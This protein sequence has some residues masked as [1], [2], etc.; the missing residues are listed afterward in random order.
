MKRN[1]LLALL[2]SLCLSSCIEVESSLSTNNSESSNLSEETSNS[3]SSSLQQS[4]NDKESTNLQQSSTPEVSVPETSTP[5]VSVP[6][7]ST[8][9][10]SVPESSIPEEST[11]DKESSTPEDSSSAENVDIDPNATKIELGG[12]GDYVTSLNNKYKGVELFEMYNGL[13]E[14]VEGSQNGIIKTKYQKGLQEFFNIDNKISIKVDI[15]QSELVKINEYHDKGNEESYRICD[16]DITLNDLIFHYE[17]VGIRLKGNTSRGHVVSG[18]K[19]NLRHYKLNFAEAF[20]DEFRSD[21]MTWTDEEA[22]AYRDD[23]TFFGLEKLDIRWNRNQEKTYIREYYAYEMYRNNGMLAPHTNPF[24]LSF[25]VDGNNQNAG[26]YLAVEPIDKDFLKR[27]LAKSYRNG[28]LYKLGWTNVG[29]TFDSV[30]SRLFGEETQIVSGDGFKTLKYPYDI[31]TNKKT[32]THADIKNFINLLNST[33]ASNFKQMLEANT[34]YDMLMKYFAISYL[35]GDPDDL[36][37]N[38]NNTYVYFIP[39]TETTNAL[40]VF[41]PT[42]HDRVLGSSGGTNPSEMKHN[43]YTDPFAKKTGY[44]ENNMPLYKKSIL[45]S[46]NT[47]IRNDYLN[48]IQGVIDSSYMSIDTFKTYYNKAKA[49]YGNSTTLGNKFNDSDVGFSLNENNDPNNNSNLSIEKYLTEKVNTASK[50]IANNNG[51]NTPS[52]NPN[53]YDVIFHYYTNARPYANLELWIWSNGDG[54]PYSWTGT[55]EFGAYYTLNSIE[56]NDP[57]RIG[58]IVRTVGSWDWQTKSKY[59]NKNEFTKDSSGV[60]HIYAINDSNNNLLLYKTS[61]EALANS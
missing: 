35:L 11:S 13:T 42:D 21:V 51:N 3:S 4:S 5:E 1:S 15:A 7:T 6:E 60:T 46:T 27:N 38:F 48:A 18:D 23:R 8:P 58:I 61:Q 43:V 54:S 55:D 10:V 26:V 32:T 14:E 45:T 12:Y 50:A 53:D 17:D 52:V 30:D 28:D 56:Y 33:S 31:K 34:K 44:S 24:N 9:E 29:A 25:N 57:N 47:E 36:R 2:M 37:G 59:V 40:A 39:K 49:H 16:L 41:I 19:L 20:D 22:L